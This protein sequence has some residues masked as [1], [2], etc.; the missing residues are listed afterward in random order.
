MGLATTIGRATNTGA[1]TATGTT[2]P[3][4]NTWPLAGFIATRQP[5]TITTIMTRCTIEN[6]P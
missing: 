3:G 4:Q 1:G 6:P 5:Q 2:P